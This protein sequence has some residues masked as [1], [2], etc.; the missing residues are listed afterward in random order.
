[1]EGKAVRCVNTPKGYLIGKGLIHRLWM[2]MWTDL[3]TEG[4]DRNKID[5]QPNAVFLKAME[6][7]KT[8]AAVYQ[9]CKVSAERDKG[10]SVT[11][12]HGA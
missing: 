5:K 1:M 9:L 10:S 8:R 12:L 6:V 4:V 7:T 2:Q 11:R 3:L